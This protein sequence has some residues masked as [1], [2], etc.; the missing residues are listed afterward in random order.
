MVENP[1]VN[2]QREKPIAFNGNNNH[3][4]E[5][6][7]RFFCVY[8][9]A[10]SCGTVNFWAGFIVILVKQLISD[11]RDAIALNTTINGD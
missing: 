3:G 10:Q 6:Y 7:N 11:L 9:S 2:P 1:T 8:T 4:G 5:T